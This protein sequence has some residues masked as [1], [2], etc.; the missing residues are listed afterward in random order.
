MLPLFW[1]NR[2]RHCVNYDTRLK[3]GAKA[4][5]VSLLEQILI[6][7]RHHVSLNLT[8]EVHRNNNHDQQRSTTEI[9]RNIETKIQE[10]GNQANERQVES[11]TESQT[12]EHLVDVTCRLL[13]RTNTRNERTTLF[14]VVCGLLGLKTSAV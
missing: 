2:G 12:H 3:T 8:H 13:T 9:E 10:F 7:V 11:A 4:L 6:L 1:L 14:Q 5:E